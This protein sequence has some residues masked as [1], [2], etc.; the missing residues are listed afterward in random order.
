MVKRHAAPLFH[1]FEVN[2]VIAG[3]LELKKRNRDAYNQLSKQMIKEND[4]HI[5]QLRNEIRAKQ[6]AQCKCLN[7]DEYVIREAFKDDKESSLEMQR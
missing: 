6:V 1:R 2:S 4:E 7:A 3:K 5:A